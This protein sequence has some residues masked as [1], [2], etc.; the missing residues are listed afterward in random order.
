MA[1]AARWVSVYPNPVVSEKVMHEELECPDPLLSVMRIFLEMIVAG[2]VHFSFE[3][4][5][6]GCV[7]LEKLGRKLDASYFER[8]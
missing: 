8:S 3:P 5:L 4:A 6:N 7:L 2:S 1:V